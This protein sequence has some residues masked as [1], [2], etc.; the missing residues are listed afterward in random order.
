M[1]IQNNIFKRNYVFRFDPP[2]FPGKTILQCATSNKVVSY[3]KN[4]EFES[5]NITSI[6]Y[7][8]ENQILILKKNN[9]KYKVRNEKK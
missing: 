2:D 7:N 3:I 8:T 5:A 4:I 1:S 9:E 6:Q